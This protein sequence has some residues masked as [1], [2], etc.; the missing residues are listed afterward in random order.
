MLATIYALC[1][2]GTRTVRYIG[3]TRSPQQR[4]KE[5]LR[6]SSHL[7]THLGNW[8]RSLA[9]EV[10][11]LVTLRE[12]PES[13]GTAAEIKYIRIA[14]ESLG[15]D[16]VNSTDG[17]DGVTMT[18][19]IR[20]KLSKRGRDISEELRVRRGRA[21]SAAKKGVPISAETRHKRRGKHVGKKNPNFGKCREGGT[22]KFLGVSLRKDTGK[23]RV[24]VTL[25]GKR[26]NVG[27]FADEQDAAHKYDEAA[28]TVHGEAAVLNF[29]RI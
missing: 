9:G 20:E 24:V 28:I 12:V 26:I 23:F 10:P 7:K 16:L 29:P 27:C 1:E 19:E 8:L 25:A 5:H 22:S 15:M 18:P 14:R 2:P 11:N 17:G 13:E 3:K 6:I 21:I 4:L